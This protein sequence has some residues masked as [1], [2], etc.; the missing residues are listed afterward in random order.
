MFY[1]AVP[2]EYVD[3]AIDL[4]TDVVFCSVY[5]QREIDKEVEVI[6]DEIE[7]Y[8]DSPADLIYDEFENIIFKSH[9]LGHNILGTKEHVR[10]F[11]TKDAM[12]FTRKYY[13]PDNAI[14]YIYGG[15]KG[16]VIERLL[17]KAFKKHGLASLGDL[18]ALESLGDLG[19]QDPLEF[20]GK[21]EDLEEHQ[22]TVGQTIVREKGTHQAHIMLGNLAYDDSEEQRTK[23]ISLYLLNNIVGGPAMNSKLN[24]VLREHHGLVYTVE[25]SMVVYTGT[26]L[27]CCYLGCDEKDINKCLK[28]VIRELD[29][30]RNKTISEQK[31]KAAKRQLKGQIGIDSDNHENFALDF[32]SVFLHDNEVRDLVS[33]YKRIDAVTPQDIQIV[34]NEVFDPDKM[35]T[36]IYK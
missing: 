10:A 6:C 33:L 2:K 31:L 11:T 34:A 8:N 30:F 35:T 17:Q 32:G 28:L 23:R 7:S 36:L 22:E 1:A 15:G 9:P 12:R 5:P 29:K 14:F 19:V 13:R 3:R 18:G 26:G 24:I 4:L 20:Q 27:W 16:A 25:S 21:L